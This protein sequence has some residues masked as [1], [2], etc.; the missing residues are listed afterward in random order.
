MSE[1]TSIDDELFSR[2]LDEFDSAYRAN[3]LNDFWSRQACS[4][5]M[6]ERVEKAHSGLQ[7]LDSYLNR[8]T[9]VDDSQAAQA[10]QL[11][12]WFN[13][14]LSLDRFQIIRE[15]GRGGFGIVY[16]AKDPRLNRQV[17][18]KIP[19]IENVGKHSL[20]NR[21]I[22]EAEIAASLDHPN[23]VP[24]FEVGAAGNVEHNIYIVSLF[25]P[26]EPLSRWLEQN[27]GVLDN[28]QK[29]ALLICVCDAMTYCHR[30]GILHRDIKPSNILLFPEPCGNLPFVPRITDF[31]LAK[32]QESAIAETATS[33][34]L[35]TPLYMAPEQASSQFDKISPA[36]D[37]YAIGVLFYELLTGRPPFQGTMAEILDKVRHDSPQPLRQ[38]DKA[39]SVDLETIC[40]KCL[41][42]APQD[43]YQDAS[44]LLDDLLAFASGKPIQGR[45][46]SLPLQFLR[47]SRKSSTNSRLVWLATLCSITVVAII[48]NSQLF[49]RLNQSHSDQ[50]DSKKPI[51]S[52]DLQGSY[53][54]YSSDLRKAHALWQFGKT[55][56]SRSLLE[57]LSHHSNDSYQRNF[58]WHFLNDRTHQ[59]KQVYVGLP[60]K[61]LCADLS[62]DM[63]WIV[64]ADRKGNVSIWEIGNPQPIRNFNYSDKEVCD[65]AFSPNGKMLATTGQDSMIH[66]WSSETWEELMFFR[67]P[68]GTNTSLDWSPD[69]SY[70]ISG[71]RAKRVSIWSLETEQRVSRLETVEDVVRNV[72]WASNGKYVA[73][74]IAGKVAVWNVA[75][76]SLY[77]QH[78]FHYDEED[79]DDSLYA[80]SF[81]AKSDRLFSGGTSKRIHAIELLHPERAPRSVNARDEP[82]SFAE[83]PMNRLMVSGLYRGGPRIWSSD[84]LGE[85]VT[86]EESPSTIRSVQVSKDERRL[87]SA[88]EDNSNITLWDLTSIVGYEVAASGPQILA[89]R[90]NSA[91]T[92]YASS[93]EEETLVHRTSDPGP[94]LKLSGVSSV[95]NFDQGANL[96]ARSTGSTIE[97]W[98]V[99]NNT[100]VS[101]LD[102]PTHPIFELA[103]SPDN[104]F[105][106]A[107]SERGD[108][109][110]YNLILRKNVAH[111][112]SESS[113]FPTHAFSSDGRLLVAF[114]KRASV[115]DCRLEIRTTEDGRLVQSV[116]DANSSES[117]AANRAFT[118]LFLAQDSGIAVYD[119]RSNKSDST[120]FRRRQGIK[121]ITISPD[122]KILAA[123]V[124]DEGIFLWDVQSGQEL[125]PILLTTEF[126]DQLEFTSNSVL[127]CRALL[128]S[129]YRF[130]S[131]SVSEDH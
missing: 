117:I 24:V 58:A 18:I 32:A 26:G 60:S 116:L 48:V 44:D 75:D 9:V 100:L 84:T 72:A 29:L 106:M 2:L 4:L 42:K 125:F 105:L 15:I 22:Q 33:A 51:V 92:V 53:D 103:F 8:Q 79:E 65:V 123:W 52:E 128:D 87:L 101:E 76:W 62:P 55:Q 14:P 37:V 85:I 107:H 78:A 31:G 10:L 90:S 127:Q 23:I 118:Q 89:Q 7:K 95:A 111:F 35:G 109:T 97:I 34:M 104:K 130:L 28:E 131:F 36:T 99:K 49:S 112:A 61:L 77:C 3:D 91:H 81:T 54:K 120:H 73:A 68:G 30:R 11:S 108:W 86:I 25:C 19:R 45:R 13:N 27:P 66:V 121:R 113:D 50:I 6:R 39:I 98:D 110:L 93:V 1:D 12:S 71:S 126:V 70:I 43:R 94:I 114:R 17:A 69:S 41:A 122:D 119:I 46:P 59:Q 102:L 38:I 56:E 82:F 67:E 5:E 20:Q 83:A 64:G 47:W 40:L 21:F 88:S 63:R 96:L 74:N 80:L 57:S 124:K 129:S 115:Q 16:L